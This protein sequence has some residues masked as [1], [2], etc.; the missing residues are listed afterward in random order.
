MKQREFHILHWGLPTPQVHGFIHTGGIFPLGWNTGRHQSILLTAPIFEY[1]THNITLITWSSISF[2]ISIKIMHWIK[3]KRSTAFLIT[4]ESK[5]PLFT[6]KSELWGK[7][8]GEEAFVDTHT[9]EPWSNKTQPFCVT[10][11]CPRRPWRRLGITSIDDRTSEPVVIRIVSILSVA[12]V[13]QLAG[14]ITK[15]SMLDHGQRQTRPN[16]WMG[17]N[18]DGC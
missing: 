7:L 16:M 5:T 10:H 14:M 9:H 15:P 18:P 12:D 11:A 6:D 4:Y 17:N 1:F 3:L 13:W 2:N 8:D